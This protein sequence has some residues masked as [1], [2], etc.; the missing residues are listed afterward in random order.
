M[1]KGANKAIIFHSQTMWQAGTWY[2]IN[3]RQNV[4]F[5]SVMPNKRGSGTVD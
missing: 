2:A 1:Y 3:V 5:S 4:K